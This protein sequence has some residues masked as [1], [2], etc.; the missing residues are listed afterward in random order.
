MRQKNCHLVGNML[1]FLQH[2][3]DINTNGLVTTHILKPNMFRFMKKMAKMKTKKQ[4]TCKR[5]K[6]GKALYY[7]YY[8]LYRQLH[9]PPRYNKVWDLPPCSGIPNRD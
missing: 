1:I 6:E 9:R 8:G 5:E 2:C 4:L 7:Q 3:Y